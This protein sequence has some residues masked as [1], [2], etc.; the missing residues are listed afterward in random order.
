[1][2]ATLLFLFLLPVGLLLAQTPQKQLVE[3]VTEAEYAQALNLAQQVDITQIDTT[4]KRYSR[5]GSEIVQRTGRKNP[6]AILLLPFI[7]L[8]SAAKEKTYRFSFDEVALAW[9]VG[10]SIASPQKTAWVKYLLENTDTSHV[11]TDYFNISLLEM[12]CENVQADIVKLLLQYKAHPKIIY[13][14]SGSHLDGTYQQRHTDPKTE[15]LK[16]WT[17]KYLAY[18]SPDHPQQADALAIVESLLKEGYQLSWWD[19]AGAASPKLI[20]IMEKYVALEME[21]E[22]KDHTLIDQ[23]VYSCDVPLYKYLQQKGYEM[24]KRKYLVWRCA[25]ILEY[26]YPQIIQ[27]TDPK[28]IVDLEE[29]RAEEGEVIHRLI[30]SY[31]ENEQETNKRKLEVLNILIRDYK[32]NIN[33]RFRADI[34][35][36][37]G[38]KKVRRV[39][40]V[41]KKYLGFTPLHAAIEDENEAIVKLLIGRLANPHIACGELTAFRYEYISNTTPL[42]MAKAIY[43]KEKKRLEEDNPIQQKRE[44]IYLLLKDYTKNYHKLTKK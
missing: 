2:K 4:I 10:D 21:N 11:H 25:E 23:A 22:E 43:K 33:M 30:R 38:V 1:M 19:I 44:R 24:T 5:S 37:W 17:K 40:R 32:A 7:A 36:G 14:T 3:A 20:K 31:G 29:I 13:I 27:S 6:L 8:E 34:E 35:Q 28:D 39:E 9:A 18:L 41:N 12:A 42:E 16:K 15:Y 26:L